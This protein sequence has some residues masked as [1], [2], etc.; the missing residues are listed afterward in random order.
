MAFFGLRQSLGPIAAWGLNLDRNRIQVTPNTA[1]TSEPGIFAVG[2]IAT[3][4]NKQK[5]IL[6]GFSE[7]SFAAHRAF[8]YARPGEVL[9]FEHSTHKG[10]PGSG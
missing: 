10:L 7:A 2:D 5:L 3:Y 6:T 4:D 1:E 8:A 9:H